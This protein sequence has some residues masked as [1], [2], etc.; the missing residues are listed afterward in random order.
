MFLVSE[1]PLQLARP[2]ARHSFPH[3]SILRGGS[4]PLQGYLAYKKTHPPNTLQQDHAL[5]PKGVLR[6]WVFLMGEVPLYGP[7][8]G[9]GSK[10][11]L[12]VDLFTCRATG[13]PRLQENAPH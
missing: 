12:A 10:P 5:V 6:G 13:V 9:P 2:R 3:P 4:G 1:V 11:T 7:E 8:A